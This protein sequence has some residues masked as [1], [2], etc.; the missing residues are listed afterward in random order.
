MDI[1]LM[2]LCSLFIFLVPV[3]VIWYMIWRKSH[4]EAEN[5]E[6]LQNRENGNMSTRTQEISSTRYQERP[7]DIGPSS[8]S[9]IPQESQQSLRVNLPPEIILTPTQHIITNQEYDKPPSYESLYN[10]G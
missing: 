6:S 2:I 9:V 7:I 10:L 3:I 1:V 4:P 5:S 8:S